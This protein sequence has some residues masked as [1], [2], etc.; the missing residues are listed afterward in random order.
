M[1]KSNKMIAGLVI[2]T[3]AFAGLAAMPVDDASL[4]SAVQ[5]VAYADVD[6]SKV[7]LTKASFDSESKMYT[8]EFSGLSASILGEIN[9]FMLGT[10]VK[11]NNS[12]SLGASDYKLE[13]KDGKMI[14]SFPG[15]N[16]KSIYIMFKNLY[17][18]VDFK[19][20]QGD[21]VIIE[22]AQA[23]NLETYRKEAKE[24]LF[25]QIDKNI[26]DK[27]QLDY[28]N[29]IYA[30]GDSILAI[31]KDYEAII[32]MFNE[33]AQKLEKFVATGKYSDDQLNAKTYELITQGLEEI[34]S[35]N[36]NKQETP[37]KTEKKELST[38]EKL[39]NAI[40]QNKITTK[41]AQLLLDTV[42]NLGKDLTQKLQTL[43]KESEALVE[44]AEKMLVK[45]EQAENAG[46]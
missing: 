32:L 9:N 24:L 10:Y 36:T 20:I 2:G 14:L 34:L 29:K 23:L 13:D 6:T 31:S 5:N 28:V 17:L 19:P 26:F 3:M 43:I 42:P 37:K 11:G 30:R 1:K 8:L 21:K 46:K 22:F 38:A 12:V 27:K 7:R 33:M 41:A 15:E 18:N 35:T 39:K 16:V 4:N 44:K 25:D 40:N 45:L